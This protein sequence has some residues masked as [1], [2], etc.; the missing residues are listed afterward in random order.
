MSKVRK[1]TARKNREAYK[2]VEAVLVSNAPNQKGKVI[3]AVRN[4]K[5]RIPRIPK[6][7]LVLPSVKMPRERAPR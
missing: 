6:G 1:S 5:L 7:E 3:G 4:G 2:G